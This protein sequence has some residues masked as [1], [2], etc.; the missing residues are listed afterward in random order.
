MKSPTYGR[1]TSEGDR[2]VL[3]DIPPHVAIRLKNMFARISK[4]QTEV[5]TLPMSDEASADL[6]WF[7]HRYPFRMSEDDLARLAKMREIQARPEMRKLYRENAK[8]RACDPEWRAFLSEMI[9]ERSLDPIAIHNH[10]AA[11]ALLNSDPEFRARRVET[12]KKRSRDPL[13]R[14]KMADIGR[15]ASRDPVLRKRRSVKMKE[16]YAEPQRREERRIEALALYADPAF[17]ARR[18]EGI[19]KRY[20]DPKNLASH[21]AKTRARHKNPAFGR[22]GKMG[23]HLHWAKVHEAA[24]R[25]AAAEGQVEKLKALMAEAG[26]DPAELRVKEA[27]ERYLEKR[28]A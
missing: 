26:H 11:M 10:R 13:W 21:S 5:F 2:W 28:A 27:A 24:G 18:L 4:T 1:L 16:H 9:K 23:I 7:C 8:K 15:K 6:C 3:S 14:A 25:L 20:S 19:R 17:A 12:L 22:S